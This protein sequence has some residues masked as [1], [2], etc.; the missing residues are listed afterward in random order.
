MVSEG[1]GP[2]SVR[3]VPP[4]STIAIR[5]Q[6]LQAMRNMEVGAAARPRTTT[7]TETRADCLHLR[8]R[9]IVAQATHTGKAHFMMQPLQGSMPFVRSGPGSDVGVREEEADALEP[10]AN[11]DDGALS[12]KHSAQH[13]AQFP[14]DLGG[15]GRVD[16]AT[17]G[18]RRHTR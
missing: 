17:W 11:A 10:E 18:I 15:L 4:F 14:E 2:A 6:P 9:R 8:G 3:G 1:I 12:E 7:N 13:G 5:T 16:E